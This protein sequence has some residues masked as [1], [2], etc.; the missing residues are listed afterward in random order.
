MVEIE[1]EKVPALSFRTDQVEFSQKEL[2]LMQVSSGEHTRET[3][4][5]SFA[6]YFGSAKKKSFNVVYQRLIKECIIEEK[7]GIVVRVEEK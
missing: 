7:D 3:L 4:Y 6:A 2:I 1:G 5:E